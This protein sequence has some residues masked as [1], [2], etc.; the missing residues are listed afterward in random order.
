[1]ATCSLSFL[2]LYPWPLCSGS[3]GISTRPRASHSVSGRQ[4]L[5]PKN[6]LFR[7]GFRC[8]RRRLRLVARVL[9]QH[10]RA[11]NNIEAH[12]LLAR[13]MEGDAQRLALPLGG[14]AGWV[15]VVLRIE[16]R[17]LFWPAAAC[18]PPPA[19]PWRRGSC[20][21]PSRRNRPRSRGTSSPGSRRGRS[22]A[23]SGQQR[24]RSRGPP[25]ATAPAAKPRGWPQGAAGHGAGASLTPADTLSPI[26]SLGADLSLGKASLSLITR[27]TTKLRSVTSWASPV[28][29][30]FRTP[31]T[32][33]ARIFS[34][35]SASRRTGRVAGLGV[36]PPSA[37]RPAPPCAPCAGPP[38]S[39]EER[40]TAPLTRKLQSVRRLS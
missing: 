3:C 21:W 28:V 31:S 14:A 17:Q 20:R 1:M 36:G 10:R 7:L 34:S 4:C 39:L 27:R 2:W 30:S 23:V 40:Q 9:H 25:A 16:G 11:G 29:H 19:P 13:G 12:R 33:R 18:A 35:V 24:G 6:P 38:K 37:P 8:R 22:R 26:L 5:F 15:G 32:S